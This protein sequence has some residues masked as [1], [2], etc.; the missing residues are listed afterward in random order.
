MPVVWGET[1][2]DVRICDKCD[3]F[4]CRLTRSVTHVGNGFNVANYLIVVEC[5]GNV[6][7]VEAV[8]SAVVTKTA[9]SLIDIGITDISV[10]SM[11][12]EV[13][14]DYGNA[15]E[16]IVSKLSEVE[17]SGKCKYS[18]EQLVFELNQ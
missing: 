4:R 17:C 7:A 9:F 10:E 8:G 13:R 12:D 3:L 15:I 6:V 5:D 18:A 11:P 16:R 1:M 2:M 14:Q